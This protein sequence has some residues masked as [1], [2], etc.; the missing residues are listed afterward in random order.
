VTDMT[1]DAGGELA[2][3]RRHA[4]GHGG[5]E[6][7]GHDRVLS[8][9]EAVLLSLVA[10]VAAWSGYCAASWDTRSSDLLAQSL[11]IQV[12][13]Q[14]AKEDALQ[15]RTFDSVAFDAAFGAYVAHDRPAFRLAIR[16]L[17]PEY[18]RAFNAWLALRPLKN[19]R[20]PADPSLMPQYHVAQQDQARALTAK[21]HASFL[22][23]S[24]AG[25]TSDKYVRITV[26][27]ATVLFLIGIS[28]HF[29]VA[30]ARYGLI[31]IGGVLIT[32]SLVQMLG[33]PGPPG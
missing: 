13:A 16:R 20:A 2:E 32:Y 25:N 31:G 4:A 10:L 11:E 33:L 9:L 5:H 17:R 27:L 6:R 21:A 7:S 15:I 18:R 26:I 19:P 22:A 24:A 8:I 12:S 29:S 1:S 23:A 30:G 3:R 14:A 28:G